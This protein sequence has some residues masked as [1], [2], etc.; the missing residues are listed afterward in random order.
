[1]KCEEKRQG[2]AERIDPNPDGSRDSFQPHPI[3]RNQRGTDGRNIDAVASAY[4]EEIANSAKPSFST[5]RFLKTFPNEPKWR[6]W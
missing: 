2:V 4:E 6:N 1:M 3:A 5:F